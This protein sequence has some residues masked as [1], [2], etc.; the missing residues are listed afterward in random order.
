MHTHAHTYTQWTHVHT[1]YLCS[2]EQAHTNARLCAHMHT[3]I[4]TCARTCVHARSHTHTQAHTHWETLLWSPYTISKK[5][6]SIRMVLVTRHCDFSHPF[7]YN[8]FLHTSLWDS[9]PS[10]FRGNRHMRVAKIAPDYSFYLLSSPFHSLCVILQKWKRKH[11][12][13]WHDIT[14]EEAVEWREI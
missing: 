3:Y 13:G 1:A 2:S 6:T 11:Y 7:F 9:V 12:I 8:N 10:N 4:H 5:N 14:C